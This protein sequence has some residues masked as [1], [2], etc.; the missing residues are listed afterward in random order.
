MASGLADHP[1]NICRLMDLLGYSLDDM[2]PAF[3]GRDAPYLERV[4]RDNALAL[5]RPIANYGLLTI[6]PCRSATFNV[7]AAGYRSVGEEQPWPPRHEQTSIVFLGGSTSVG[8]NLEDAETIPAVLHHDLKAQGF[9][10][11]I[12]NFAS[13]S[14]TSRNEALR[15]L[16]LIDSGLRPDMVVFLDGLNDCS[17]AFG[18]DR[19]R[20]ELDGLYQTEKSRRRM[21]FF[22]AVADYAA[23]RMNAG[24]RQVAEAASYTLPEQ[25]ARFAKLIDNPA[26]ERALAD[27][28]SALDDDAVAVAQLVW[29]RY[30]DSV[31]MI[32]SVARRHGIKT[33]FAWQPTPYF[34]TRPDQRILPGLYRVFRICTY[35]H[36]V[37]HWLAQTGFPGL[38]D[39]LDFL[40]LS[41]FGADLDGVL[42][43][44]SNHYS[45]L[46]AEAIG[47]E[48]GRQLAR[49]LTREGG[50]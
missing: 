37:Y 11:Q 43:S 12:Y 18:N 22:R 3:P 1:N 35:C 17:Y 8:F 31:T 16:D 10:T 50:Q 32:E 36:Y 13:G 2:L 38:P 26:I 47:R 21:G 30:L 28:E 29:N 19:L 15:F 44:D 40:D 48:L 34:A 46:F 41:G 39:S 9:N 24:A 6:N 33:L 5:S 42:Y 7:A 4:L 20:Q 23:T 45:P 49:R 27:G 14:W 25:A